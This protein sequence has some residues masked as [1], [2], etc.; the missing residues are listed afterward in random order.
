MTDFFTW[1]DRI[2][3]DVPAP[4]RDRMT[5]SGFSPYHTGGGCMAWKRDDAEG[6]Y[7]LISAEDA[8]L[9]GNADASEWVV[10]HYAVNADRTDETWAE[11][12]DC[13][14][15]E[16]IGILSGVKDAPHGENALALGDFLAQYP[17]GSGYVGLCDVCGKRL[18]DY[19]HCEDC[20]K[21]WVIE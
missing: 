2:V 16:A 12:L 13:T 21:E 11:V 4:L 18:T 19:C 6:G 14:L 20:S 3:A 8:Q 7:W 17:S 1:F 9:D 5:A 15:G 10:S